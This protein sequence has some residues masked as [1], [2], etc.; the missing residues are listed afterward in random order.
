MFFLSKSSSP[1]PSPLASESMLTLCV[2]YTHGTGN[3]PKYQR[4][5]YVSQVVPVKSHLYGH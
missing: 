2:T 3:K 4:F 5:R 1:I